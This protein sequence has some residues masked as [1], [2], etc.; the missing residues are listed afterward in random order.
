QYQ[1]LIQANV[2]RVHCTSHGYQT[3]QVPWASGSSRYTELFEMR[4]LALLAMSSL[5]AVSRFFKLSWGAIDRIMARAVYRGLAKR[6][7]INTDYL[8]VDETALK[9]GHEYV[10]LLSNHEGQVLAVSEGRSAASF[11][12]C[13]TQLPSDALRQ[14]QSICMDM[15]PAY[16]KA[17][18]K[19]LPNAERK[20]AFD[21]FHVAKML[22]EAVN[23]I[24]KEELL[25]LAP[26]MRQE[27]HRTRFYWLKRRDNLSK[28][29]R[30]RVNRLIPA[31][32]NTALAWY[33]KEQARNIWHGNSVRGTKQRWTDWIALVKASGLK[34]LMAVADTIESKLWGIL[35][36]M[37]FG[38][39]NG[40]AEA[41]NSQIRLLRVKAMGYRNSE[42]F[43]RA[44]FFHFG[45]LD[46]GFHQ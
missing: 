24:R 34:P 14:T 35:N 45:K 21:H 27:A 11:D 7:Q 37:R 20:I 32:M 29:D 4:V 26:S 30:E 15:S 12:A 9:K 1:T 18:R 31:M 6:K 10:T 22:T 13:L 25:R 16:I 41:I 8:L 38:L 3:L 44:I 43:Q 33:F 46:M 28:P 42:R 40:L 39:S 2:P 5:N 17:A 19:A 36:A 23:R